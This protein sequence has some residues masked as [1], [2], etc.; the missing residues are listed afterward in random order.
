MV[1]FGLCIACMFL[2]EVYGIIETKQRNLYTV[3]LKTM[4]AICFVTIGV[5]IFRSRKTFYVHDIMV[6]LFFGA[7]G[8][9][10]LAINNIAKKRK[11]L[12]FIIGSVLFF[13]GHIFYIKGLASFQQH[14]LLS[15]GIGIV[16]CMLLGVFLL[17]KLTAKKVVKGFGFVYLCVVTVMMVMA[18]VNSTSI[19]T[20]SSIR[21]AVGAFLFWLSDI[22]LILHSFGG[23]K[24]NF[25]RILNLNLYFS[26]QLFI[27]M[28]L[29]SS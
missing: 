15:V 24:S 28:S 17:P 2:Q 9:F 22:V 13:I 1:Y 23:Y 7:G 4:A 5:L 20:N 29:M 18:I 19:F 14:I 21:F 10:F 11:D 26:G 16:C 6:G 12:F 25:T 27:A 8:D 3:L